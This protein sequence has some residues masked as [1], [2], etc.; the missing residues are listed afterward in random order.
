[1]PAWLADARLTYLRDETSPLL[2]PAVGARVQGVLVADLGRADLDR[3]R[4]FESVEYEPRVFRVELLDGSHTEAQAFAPSARA[5]HDGAHW[6][7]EA[8]LAQHK[9]ED[10][11]ETRL[12][13]ALYGYLDPAE[14]DRRWNRAR[15]EGRA[16]EDLVAEVQAGR[17]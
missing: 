8:W 6:S 1:M 11:G 15:D 3:I 4:F 5:E 16:L 9:A 7:F 10:L 13:M 12:W 17:R 14:A 2:I